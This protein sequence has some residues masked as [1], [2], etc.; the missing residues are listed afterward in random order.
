MGS[1]SC[2]DVR[3]WR[4]AVRSCRIAG[5]DG[6][7]WDDPGE[8]CESNDIENRS[9]CVLSAPLEGIP[10]GVERPFP[11][12]SWGDACCAVTQSASGDMGRRLGLEED[13]LWRVNDLLG[14]HSV[15]F[16]AWRRT[17]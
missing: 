12:C 9:C 8:L 6:P 16:M 10:T 3:F 15:G 14:S 7:G 1:R 4:A 17:D 13:E 5:E 11:F 2:R